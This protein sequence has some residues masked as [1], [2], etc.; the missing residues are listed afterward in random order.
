MRKDEEE[1]KEF[2]LNE[3]PKC[4]G[5]YLKN[6]FNFKY[7]PAMIQKDEYKKSLLNLKNSFTFTDLDEK[8]PSDFDLAMKKLHT[9]IL[10]RVSDLQKASE[11]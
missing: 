1:S 2:D 9:L 3:F 6:G 11:S 4:I 10:K 7:L 5:D 8:N